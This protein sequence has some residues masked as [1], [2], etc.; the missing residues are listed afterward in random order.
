MQGVPRYGLRT[1]A[2]Y[3]LLQGLAIQGEIRPQGVATLKRHWEGLLAGRW[4]YVHDR[5]LTE[6]EAPDGPEPEYRVLELR[7]ESADI[8]GETENEAA[9]RRVQIKRIESPTAEIF[10]LGFTVHDVEQAISDL[11]AM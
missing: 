10:R 3:D 4:T 1:R 8:E 6:G 5:E 2:D 11:E 7:D 9:V